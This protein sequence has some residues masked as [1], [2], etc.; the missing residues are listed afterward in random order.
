MKKKL[1]LILSLLIVFGLLFSACGGANEP[2][3]EP[4]DEPADE[5]ANEPAAD[6]PM[7]EPA[8]VTIAGQTIEALPEEVELTFSTVGAS[9]HALPLWIA[10]EQ[11]WLEELNI[12]LEHISFDNG[13]IQMEALGADS[14]DFGTTGQG[15]VFTGVLKYDT[16]ILADLVSDDD[17]MR[18]WVRAD[19]PIAQAGENPDFPGIYGTAEDWEGVEIMTPAGT[20]IHFVVVKTLEKLELTEEDITLANMSHS[21]AFTALTAGQGEVAGLMGSFSYRIDDDPAYVDVSTSNAIGG[22]L[23]IAMMVVNPSVVDD[24]VKMDA[25]IKALDVHFAVV[26]WINT[27]SKEE[28]TDWQIRMSEEKGLS[29]DYDELFKYMNGTRIYDFDYSYNLQTTVSDDGEL[30]LVEREI[31]DP[32]KFFVELDKFTDEDVEKM[33]SGY[34]PTE[35]IE[36][37]KEARE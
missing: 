36:L 23:A 13:P 14:W 6:E 35:Y 5:P 32:L 25:I 12:K 10:R 28:L 26:D 31:I 18:V 19:H 17:M 15:G 34:F 29:T 2:A 7:E 3:N 30:T 11:G 37:V 8:T 33:S 16:P 1:F 20:I 9:V 24:P 21:N 4:A 27:I 22:G